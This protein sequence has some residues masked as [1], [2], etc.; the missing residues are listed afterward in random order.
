M[1]HTFNSI[2][3]INCMFFVSEY[4]GYS[5]NVHSH[6]LIHCDNPLN[7]IVKLKKKFD[8]LGKNQIELVNNDPVMVN[9]NGELKVGYYF[10]KHI[11][12]D[13]D[14]DFLVK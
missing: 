10:T 14:Y 13:V 1:E 2:E 5:K 7:T 4:S 12:N 3:S 11:S 8:R 9:E 6:F